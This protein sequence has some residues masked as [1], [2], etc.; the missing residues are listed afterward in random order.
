MVVLA[1]LSIATLDIDNGLSKINNFQVSTIPVLNY[2]LAPEDTDEDAEDDATGEEGLSPKPKPTTA[3]T[4]I[5]L[6]RLQYPA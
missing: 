5:V 1:S 2:A 6:H 3:P 4:R